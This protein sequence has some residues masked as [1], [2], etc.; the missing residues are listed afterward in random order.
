MSKKLKMVVLSAVAAAGFGTVV[1]AANTTVYNGLNKG[2][3]VTG[4]G[5]CEVWTNG[6][7]DCFRPNDK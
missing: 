5:G 1:L 4:I 7:F 2:F 3:V 6:Q